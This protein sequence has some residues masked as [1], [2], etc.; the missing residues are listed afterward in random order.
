[1]PSSFAARTTRRNAATPR[2]WPSA[3]G[4]PRAAAQRPLPSMMIATCN[5]VSEGSDP[6]VAG[7]AT[8]DIGEIPGAA[9]ARFARPQKCSR[10]VGYAHLSRKTATGLRHASN[11]QD[12][13]FLG[14]Q[15][16]VDFCNRCVGGLLDV[17]IEALLVVLGNLVI[18]LEFLDD[19]EA[20]TANVTYR[21]LGKIGIFVG[22]LD[23]FLAAFLIQLRNAQAQHLAFGRGT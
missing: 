16:L 1:M 5:G 13:L 23:E 18:L 4:R 8:F 2:R 11:G 12:F 15:Q 6:S 17:V 10:S 20:V 21:Y 22:D 7:T 14:R 3:R 19:I 9:A